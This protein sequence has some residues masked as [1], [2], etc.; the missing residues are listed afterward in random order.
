VADVTDASLTPRARDL[1]LWLCDL[2]NADLEAKSREASAAL[3]LREV[4]DFWTAE[5]LVA[6]ARDVRGR[7]G[8]R[9][10]R[11]AWLTAM[12]WLV[13]E[14]EQLPPRPPRLAPDVVHR[15]VAPLLARTLAAL[16]GAPPAAA[17]DPW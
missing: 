6:T 2:A 14:R 15:R 7:L 17:G 12:G 8:P 1:A 4:P 9:A 10:S 11:G 16:T 13:G 3:L 5:E